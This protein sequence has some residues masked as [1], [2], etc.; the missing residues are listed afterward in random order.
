MTGSEE[1]GVTLYRMTGNGIGIYGSNGFG[2][3]HVG[4][5]GSSRIVVK[6]LCRTW[7]LTFI[8]VLIVVR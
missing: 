2:G 4:Q 6:Q 8:T 1:W 7:R 3:Y 5:Y